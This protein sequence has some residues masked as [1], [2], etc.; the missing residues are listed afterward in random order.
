MTV[1]KRLAWFFPVLVL[2]LVLDQLTK[3]WAR[4]A[5]VEGV[6]KDVIGAFWHWHLSFNTGVAF[7]M[8]A[9]LGA[10]RIVLPIIAAVVFAGV[11][12]MAAKSEPTTR[13][14]VLALG[15][16]GAGALGNVIDRIVFG[17][18][19]DFV[20]WTAFGHAWPIFNVADVALV[21]GVIVMLVWRAPRPAAATSA[22]A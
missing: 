19:T 6:S 13:A 21:V 14:Q 15:L 4:G 5:L 8:F 3:A 16:I 11:V 12:W 17:K 20:L 9:N 10:G 22:A 18:V 1:K 2:S 7:S